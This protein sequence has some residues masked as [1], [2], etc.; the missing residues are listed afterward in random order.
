MKNRFKKIMIVSFVFAFCFMGAAGLSFGA[1]PKF[2]KVAGSSITGSTRSR[3]SS[4]IDFP[5]MHP[6]LPLNND[7][8]PGTYDAKLSSGISITDMSLLLMPLA[9]A[10]A[11]GRILLIK[12]RALKTLPE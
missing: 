12:Y 11:S 1:D 6:L 10:S 9:A 5:F 8:S 3:G 2:I 4:F 7:G